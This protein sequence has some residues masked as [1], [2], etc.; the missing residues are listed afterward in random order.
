MEWTALPYPSLPRSA[1]YNIHDNFFMHSD[2][3]KMVRVVLLTE[4]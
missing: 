1:F 4:R 2:G 3:F